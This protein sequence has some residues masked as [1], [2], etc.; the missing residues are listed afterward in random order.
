MIQNPHQ[1]PIICVDTGATFSCAKD[2]ET[3]L[4]NNGYPDAQRGAIA[5]GCEANERPR[6]GGRY[7]KRYGM[8]WRFN[9]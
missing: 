6:Y 4:R 1:R 8:V 3:H 7:A 2:V 5:A 9:D